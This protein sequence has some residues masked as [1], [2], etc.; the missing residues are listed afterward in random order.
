MEIQEVVAAGP[1]WTQVRASD[2]NTYTLSGNRNWRNNN[3]GNIE[4]GSYARRHG[5]V[6]T[7]GR[8]AVFP[9]FNTG[10]AAK[11]NL[12]FSSPDYKEMSVS[13][14]ISAYAPPRENAT[15]AYY[16]RVARDV[17]VPS[18]TLLSDLTPEQR[19]RMLDSMQRVEGYRAGKVT[20][21]F[22]N[23]VDAGLLTSPQA[24]P[25]AGLLADVPTPAQ[26]PQ[27]EQMAAAP[28]MP[29]ERAPIPQVDVGPP[30]SLDTLH[31]PQMTMADQYASYG[32]GKAQAV[33]NG[34]LAEDVAYQKA[35][36]GLKQGLLGQKNAYYQ[37]QQPPPQFEAQPGLKQPQQVSAPPQD[38][39]GGLFPAAQAPAAGPVMLAADPYDPAKL[40]GI[41]TGKKVAGALGGAV[42]GSLLAGPLGGLLGGWAGP[43][44]V[45]RSQLLNGRDYFPAAPQAQNNFVQRNG[46]GGLGEYGREAYDRSQQVRD[47]VDN[48]NVGLF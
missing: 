33:Q 23:P 35:M 30:A 16:N 20:D 6:G 43:K 18:D 9:S 38:V 4:Y 28:P 5:A 45:E 2:G 44:L 46:Y 3:P 42:V 19:T 27:F 25:T 29:V 8:F 14:A 41:K 21:E 32:A 37:A 10:R 39:Q 15:A 34:L 40:K 31:Q 47:I 12:L 17:G 24:Q 7:D 48:N 1:G 11:E 26:R 13:G 36:D 22:G